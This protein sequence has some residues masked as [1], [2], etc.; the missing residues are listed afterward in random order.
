MSYTFEFESNYYNTD[1]YCDVIEV[2]FDFDVTGSHDDFAIDTD[3]TDQDF[4][5]NEVSIYDLTVDREIKF[6]DFPLDEQKKIM[7][8][9]EKTAQDK[10]HEVFQNKAEAQGDHMYDCWKDG[11]Y[12]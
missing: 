4:L 6:C 2:T 1:G 11:D 8:G 10:A 9:L 7:E 12:R 5:N 3:F